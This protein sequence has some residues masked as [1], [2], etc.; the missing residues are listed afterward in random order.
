M[1]S[2]KLRA[3]E[4]VQDDSTSRRRRQGFKMSCELR[5]VEELQDILRAEGDG[6]G[7]EDDG[8]GSGYPT[9]WNAYV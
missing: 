6:G 7:S 3:E 4:G 8:E 1:I 2:C 5:M 9:S